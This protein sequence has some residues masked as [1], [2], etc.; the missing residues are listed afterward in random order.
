MKIHKMQ[1]I[2]HLLRLPR[3]CTKSGKYHPKKR[4]LLWR[5]SL[6]IRPLI[7]FV[8]ERDDLIDMSDESL[9]GIPVR[10]PIDHGLADAI[11]KLP[12]TQRECVILHFHYGYSTREIGKMMNCTQHAI[13]KHIWRA[14]QNLKE[15][16]E[17][18]QKV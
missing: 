12:P 7:W 10:T 4:N 18:D 3:I 13:Q 6:S 8:K 5:P 14:K 1:Y 2:R 15:E 16:L 9:R 11:A 17:C